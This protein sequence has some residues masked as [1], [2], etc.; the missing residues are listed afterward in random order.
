MRLI[1]RSL[2]TVDMSTVVGSCR[3]DGIVENWE[4]VIRAAVGRLPNATITSVDEEQAFIVPRGMFVA[5]AGIQLDFGRGP[6]GSELSA[7]AH[8]A[9]ER[10]VIWNSPLRRQPLRDL[11]DAIVEVVEGR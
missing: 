3:F 1:A 9:L 5:A 7:R 6:R 4:A 8:G 10:S 11:L 2:E